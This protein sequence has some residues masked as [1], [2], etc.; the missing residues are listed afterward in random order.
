MITQVQLVDAG[1]FAPPSAADDATSEAQRER[2]AQAFK[3]LPSFCR[4]AITFKPSVDSDIKVEVWMP[5]AGW[6]GRFLGVGNGGWGGS[7]NFNGLA[8]AVHQGFATA[9]TDMGTGGFSTTDR[10][11]WKVLESDERLTDFGSR[12]T[13]LMTVAAK[14][15]MQSFYGKGPQFS[16]WNACSTGGKQGLAEA[17]QFPDDYNGIVEGDPASYFTHL[18][19]SPPVVRRGCPK[20]TYRTDFS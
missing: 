17:Q 9:S 19:F 12:S 3:S 14:E 13:H 18:M 7:I 2:I 5:A 10:S 16:Y 1:S 15:L 8:Q 6:N 20:H 11:T 4:V